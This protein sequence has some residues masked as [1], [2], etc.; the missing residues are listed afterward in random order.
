MR[1]SLATTASA[2]SYSGTCGAGRARQR[3]GGRLRSL[4]SAA[5]APM[6]RSGARNAAL[7]A[8]IGSSGSPP[9]NPWLGRRGIDG[10]ARRSPD[11]HEVRTGG[12]AL[13]RPACS[14][15]RAPLP[16]PSR[17]GRRAPTGRAPHSPASQGRQPLIDL[18]NI[19]PISQMSGGL[20][21]EAVGTG[22]FPDVHV[23]PRPRAACGAL[24]P[25]QGNTAQN[26]F[27]LS[28][29][30]PTGRMSASCSGWASTSVRPHH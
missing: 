22:V 4:P 30:P 28:A 6:T 8:K 17:S 12:A 15:Y 29:T 23:K 25:D 20:E 7:P 18:L 11:G 5:V 24:D 16:A 26:A 21:I 27:V 13:L 10:R 3:R 14:P 19:R 9:Y 2:R 1:S